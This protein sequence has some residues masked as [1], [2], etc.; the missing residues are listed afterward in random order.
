MSSTTEDVVEIFVKWI[1]TR[2]GKRLYASDLGLKPFRLLIPS[3]K[4]KPR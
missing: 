1:T 2:G 4:F 3:S